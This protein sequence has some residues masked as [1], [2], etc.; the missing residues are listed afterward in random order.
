MFEMD[1]S[2]NSEISSKS[3]SRD[4]PVFMNKVSKANHHRSIGQYE[5]PL[6]LSED[7]L[8]LYNNKKVADYRLQKL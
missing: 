4:D 6:P 8:K 7:D 2:G 3:L 5:I 1:F